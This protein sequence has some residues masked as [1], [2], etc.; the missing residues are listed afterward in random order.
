MPLTRTRCTTVTREERVDRSHARPFGVS[1]VGVEQGVRSASAAP[2]A[3]SCAAPRADAK[4]ALELCDR[5]VRLVLRGAESVELGKGVL[6]V[7][8]DRTQ[9]VLERG[10]LGLE[11]AQ[12][13]QDVLGHGVGGPALGGSVVAGWP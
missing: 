11:H 13:C 8:R 5:P 12:R 3:P 1:A 6:D 2:S 10:E 9:G 4:H 7:G